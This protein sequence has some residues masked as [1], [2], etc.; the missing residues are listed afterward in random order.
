MN[1]LF[2]ILFFFVSITRL[3]A[4]ESEKQ[5]IRKAT[6]LIKDFQFQEAIPILEQA[7]TLNKD[8]VISQYMLGK[9]YYWTYQHKKALIYL[10]KAYKANPDLE[11]DLQ[12]L[13]AKT[14]HQN[15]QFDKAIEIY[16][17]E[18]KRYP[19]TSVQHLSL[20][21]S[22]ANCKNGKMLVQHPVDVKIENVGKNINTPYDEYAPVIT[23]DQ[24]VMFFTSRR[25]GNLGGIRKEDRNYYEDIY[26]SKFQDGNWTEAKNMGAPINT[27]GQD[28]PISLSPDG[29]VLYIHRDHNGGD[30]YSCNLDGE[31]YSIPQNLGEPINTDYWEPSVSISADGKTLFYSSNKP[32]G[33][34]NRDL[35]VSY[36]LENGK[37]SKGKNLGP[38]INTL[39]DEDAPFIHP[40]GK[41]LYFSSQAHSSMGGFD[42]FKSVLLANG[43]WT[44]PVNIGYPINTPDDDIYFVLTASGK[45]GY[46]A[47]AGRDDGFGGKDIYRITFPDPPADTTAPPLAFKPE[48]SITLLKGV[49]SDA[50]D[51]KPL[52]ASLM[53]VDNEA[54][55]TISVMN[56]NKVS[57]K[58]LITLTPGRNYGII[59]SAP[60]YLFCSENVDIPKTQKAYQ[61]II[62][63]IKLVPLKVG[64]KII[65]KNIF[66]D[67]DKSTLRPISKAELNRLV[68]ILK[69]NPNMRIRIGG[70]T[71]NYG[72]D[73]YNQKLSEN[74][75]GAVV[76]YLIEAGIDKKRLEYK[77]YGEL[78]PIDTNETPQG[79]QNNRRTEFE[80]LTN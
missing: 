15:L 44:K 19:V 78:E 66:F 65:L 77:G 14:L 48:L 76:Q 4:Q 51:N 38:K 36:K 31:S 22:I 18:K 63:D 5:L 27:D 20:Y 21:H 42:I 8:N 25:P 29:H 2:F 1:K 47:S 72:S 12:G 79:R 57:G 23:A 64:S 35:Y 40:D 53:I 34:G 33:H 68:K 58:Y 32:G 41:T 13:Y 69:D 54:N 49:V 7:L 16:E 26:I 45:Y 70:H 37:W 6:A 73:E 59:A 50:S 56:S 61:E 52:F 46:Y 39:M 60:G 9:S 62:K 17:K 80:I 55:D 10:E 74:R 3:F 28:A 43:E 30:V 75:A 67:F 11:P 24:E 71:D